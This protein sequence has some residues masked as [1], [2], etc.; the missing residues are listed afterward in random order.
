MRLQNRRH[1]AVDMGAAGRQCAIAPQVPEQHGAV[2]RAR[3]EALRLQPVDRTHGFGVAAEFGAERCALGVPQA[4]GV[5]GCGRQQGAA[6]G[7][8][9]AVE[10]RVVVCPPPAQDRHGDVARGVEEAQA[11]A[12][13]DHRQPTARR[14]V[15]ARQ[16]QL[17][18]GASAAAEVAVV[19]VE[20]P[21][22]GGYQRPELSDHRDAARVHMRVLPPAHSRVQRDRREIG[23]CVLHL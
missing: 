13:V 6:V 3:R 2:A 9:G 7:V 17:P 11:A 23:R 1:R 14:V 5:V 12:L 4:A 16:G 19:C 10:Y 18:S 20:L 8:P 21:V 22:A 15:P